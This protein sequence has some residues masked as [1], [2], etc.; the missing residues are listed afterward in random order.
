MKTRTAHQLAL[1][2][3]LA[4]AATLPASAQ[5]LAGAAPRDPMVPPAIARPALGTNA[6]PD[7]ALEPPPTPRQ[8]LIV[9]GRRYVV[10]ERRRYGVGDRL[11]TARIDRITESAVWVREAGNVIR[12]PLFG[13]VVKRPAAETPPPQP[14]PPP[15]A[16]ARL[17][18]SGSPALRDSH[19]STRGDSP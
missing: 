6:A 9:D 7:A 4:A 5:L 14:E 13:G 11:G 3:A 18:A 15:N 12:L 1:A 2:L 19:P 16:N 8:L 10:E 17:L